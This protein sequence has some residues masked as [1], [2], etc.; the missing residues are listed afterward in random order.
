MLLLVA[1]EIFFNVIGPL[2]SDESQLVAIQWVDGEESV[3]LIHLVQLYFSSFFCFDFAI[4]FSF[5]KGA[6]HV[7]FSIA[8]VFR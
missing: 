4:S 3:F 2:T 1:V 7:L 6:L 5:Q 8:V